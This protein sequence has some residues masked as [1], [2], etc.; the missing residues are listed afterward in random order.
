MYQTLP[1]EIE[2]SSIG[3]FITEVTRRSITQDEKSESLFNLLYQ[4]F[5]FLDE[6][7]GPITLF[8]IIFLIKL[9]RELGFSPADNFS[10]QRELFDIQQG[11]FIPISTQ[12]NYVLNPEASQY[13]Y[14]LLFEEY[15]ISEHFKIPKQI[16]QELLNQLVNFYRIHNDN[17][18]QIKSLDVLKEVFS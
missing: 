18:G 2:K 12:S 8:P 3:I 1:F 6:S 7:Q 17:F 9:S 14:S 4:S 5:S 13:L 16:R 11:Q 15:G 10:E